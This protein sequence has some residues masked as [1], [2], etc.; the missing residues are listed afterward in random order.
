MKVSEG[1]AKNTLKPW[2]SE[3]WCIEQITGDDL[4]HMEDVLYQYALPLTRYRSRSA[5]VG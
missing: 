5:G 3:Q 1:F 4:W 2:Q